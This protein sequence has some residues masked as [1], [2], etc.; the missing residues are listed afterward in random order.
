MEKKK[1]NRLYYISLLII[2]IFIPILYYPRIYG[3]DAFQIIWMAKALR[4]G[5]FFSENT[6]LI[7]P[8]SYFGYY[9]FSNI[10]IGIPVLLAFLTSF[11]NILSFGL[12]GLT[13]A[14]LVLDIFFIIITYKSAKNL[15]Y[16]Y[17]KEEWCRFIFVAAI[18]FSQYVLDF[19]VMTVST[20]IGIT[21]IMLILLNLHLKLID[22]S[23]KKIKAIF[24]IILLLFFGALLHRIWLA[25]IITIIILIFTI[26]IAK[27]KYIF[28]FVIMLIIPLCIIAYFLGLQTFLFRYAR[29]DLEGTFSFIDSSSFI[30]KTLLF[31]IYFVIRSGLLSIFFPLGVIIL[32]YKISNLLKIYDKKIFTAEN[33]QS[34]LKNI[35]LVI[36]VIPFSFLIPST[37]Y[38][39]TVFLPIILIISVQ[40]LKYFIKIISNFSKTG[41]RIIPGLL[42]VLS[43]IY[44]IFIYNFSNKI[45]LWPIY[46]LI[47]ISIGLFL[48]IFIMDKFD[49]LN[50][51][52]N[53]TDFNLIKKK[54][55][56][57]LLTTSILIF[58]ITTI[59]S[60]RENAISSPYPWENYY[61]TSEE[62]EISEFFQNENIQGL[63][64]STEIAIGQKLAAMAS[65]PIIA[66]EMSNGMPLYYG[67]ISSNDIHMNTYFSLE[68]AYLLI[69]FHYQGVIFWDWVNGVYDLSNIEAIIFL[70]KHNIQYII[71]RNQNYLD[72][73]EDWKMRRTGNLL[74]SLFSEFS[75]V[76]ST[77]HLLIWKIYS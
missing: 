24:Y 70:I 51:L 1:K 39:L 38:A 34:L 2:A 4:S 18:L 65:L 69:F 29:V 5:A 42:L 48:F 60:F 12:F 68:E 9:P 40:G 72:E 41:G 27:N 35:Y 8:I 21:I 58:S 37:F 57:I 64:L 47:S 46:L 7:S 45:N 55:G 13:E 30:G 73:G 67:A 14:I 15:G 28:S 63:I 6:W 22:G 56:I 50:S 53:I 31:S 61:Y 3:A 75:P 23:I 44:S 71:S 11:I 32:I 26:L 43:S 36:F 33:R 25:T 20:R 66:P 59:E 76:F 77:K 62:E 52:K 54:V 74:E 16:T 49:F 17:F 19:T 10:P